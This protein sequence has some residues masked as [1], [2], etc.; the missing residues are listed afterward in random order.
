MGA[1]RHLFQEIVTDANHHL[2]QEIVRGANRYLSW[3]S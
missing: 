3:K 1:N 2:F